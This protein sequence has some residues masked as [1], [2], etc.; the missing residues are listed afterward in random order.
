[1]VFAQPRL[2]GRERVACDRTFARELAAGVLG[3]FDRAR[4]AAERSCEREL[5]RRIG[6]GVIAALVKRECVLEQRARAGELAG[7]QGDVA[8]QAGQLARASALLEHALALHKG[9]DD[10]DADAA[11]ELS[12]ARALG[13]GPRAIELAEDARSKFASEGPVARDALAAAETWLREHHATV[14]AQ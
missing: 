8:L 4:A 13:G 6:V 14:A 5:D 2:G 9:S 7:L 11:I 12:L 10:S 1:M 3:E